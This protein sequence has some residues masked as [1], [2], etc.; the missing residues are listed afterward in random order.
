MSEKFDANLVSCEVCSLD[1]VVCYFGNSTLLSSLE[2]HLNSPRERLKTQFT[3]H[4]HGSPSF[5]FIYSVA[6]FYSYPLQIPPF[7]TRILK[8]YSI[9]SSPP[10]PL[11]QGDAHH[12]RR[13]VR[14]RRR[15]G[16]SEGVAGGEESEGGDRGVEAGD[17]AWRQSH[18]QRGRGSEL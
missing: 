16:E 1:K 15:K 8:P 14:R 2:T 11:S 3:L 6:P 5:V 12:P 4:L 17:P 7:Y 10:L 13:P 18:H 9:F